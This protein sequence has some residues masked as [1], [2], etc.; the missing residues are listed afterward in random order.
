MT[1]RRPG[2][3]TYRPERL[4]LSPR[5]QDVLDFAAR[6]QIRYPRVFPSLRSIAV[7]LKISRARAFQLVHGI[8]EKGHPFPGI[9]PRGVSKERKKAFEKKQNMKDFLGQVKKL[10]RQ[11]MTI[12]EMHEATGKSIRALASAL[13]QLRQGGEIERR[14]SRRTSDQMS[15]DRRVIKRLHEAGLTDKR[16][17]K[18]IRKPVRFVTNEKTAMF[19]SGELEKKSEKITSADKQIMFLRSKGR[20]YREIGKRLGEKPSWVK[21]RLKR[22]R[23]L[24]YSI[25]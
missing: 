22:L 3:P 20:T 5:E 7:D 10:H 17:A 6:Y 12:G 16:T 23:R 18:I 1:E 14:R 4:P 25:G 21:Y 11:G 9:K 19:E 8:S 13:E 2:N 24:G 15:A